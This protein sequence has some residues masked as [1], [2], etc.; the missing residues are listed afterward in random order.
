MTNESRNVNDLDAKV[1]IGEAF[2]YPGAYF[3]YDPFRVENSADGDSNHCAKPDDAVVI[4]P[5]DAWESKGDG[6]GHY[7]GFLINT[8]PE[9]IS[10]NAKCKKDADGMIWV[11]E[12]NL[13]AP[14]ITPI[15]TDP[16]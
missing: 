13:N 4:Q 5:T 6:N 10:D 12:K 15:S 7:I 8:L 11:A 16:R 9:I 1:H 3:R 2:V 14:P